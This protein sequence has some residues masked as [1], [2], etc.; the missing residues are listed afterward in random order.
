MNVTKR[1]QGWM[2]RR[3][4]IK[5]AKKYEGAP[6]REFVYLDDVSVYSLISSRLGPIATEFTDTETLSLQSEQYAAGVATVGALKGELRNKQQDTHTTSSQILRKAFVQSTFKEL[7]A[8]EHEALVIRPDERQSSL[9]QVSSLRQV[10][11]LAKSAAGDEWIVGP[12]R[13]KR[14]ELIEVEAELEADPVFQVSAIIS[15]FLE[16]FEDNPE[17]FPPGSVDGVAEAASLAKIIERL[18]VGLVPV[19][20]KVVDFVVIEIANKEHLVHREIA[21]QLPPETETWPVFVVGVAAHNLFWKDVRRVLFSHSTYRV[22]AR[23]SKSSIQKDWTP[24]KV[25]DVV[26]DVAPDFAAQI[27]FAGSGTLRAM[28]ARTSGAERSELGK[29]RRMRSAL[30]TYATLLAHHHGRSLDDEFFASSG[31]PSE[32]Q[33]NA[34]ATVESRRGA[35]RAIEDHLAA[36]LDIEIDPAYA[37]QL[38][39]G[40]SQDEGL[41]VQ[42]KFEKSTETETPIVKN[43]QSERF[44]DTELIAIYW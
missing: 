32:E 21:K 5:A 13:L 4:R 2:R 33:I 25:V 9:P 38:R 40:V 1:L 31:L 36:Q 26:K 39:S 18:L 41:H 11:E 30:I 12:E 29:Q 22:L 7:Y 20:G 24:V 16:I 14:G 23:I 17:I 35:F 28:L 3:R 37:V 44:I 8:Y 15:A 6:L 27:D 43:L 42:G 34:H 10:A 19:R